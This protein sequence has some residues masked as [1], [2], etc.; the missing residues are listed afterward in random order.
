MS[1]P[2]SQA[3]GLPADVAEAIQGQNLACKLP[4]DVILRLLKAASGSP[5]ILSRTAPSNPQGAR[6]E[7]RAVTFSSRPVLWKDLRAALA[8]H[9]AT[10]TGGETGAAASC[11][12]VQVAARV[13][14]AR[15]T[16]ASGLHGMPSPRIVFSFRCLRPRVRLSLP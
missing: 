1:S 7:R 11:D 16:D 8:A 12:I 14:F 2:I 13:W 5:W 9:T 6:Y 10:A 4:K 15:R 3:V